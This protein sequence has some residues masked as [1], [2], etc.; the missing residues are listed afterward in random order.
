MLEHLGNLTDPA[1]QTVFPDYK[2]SLQMLKIRFKITSYSS[3]INILS[4]LAI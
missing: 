2:L 3:K 1:M 4:D